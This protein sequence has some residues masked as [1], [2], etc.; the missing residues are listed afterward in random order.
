[1]TPFQL[2][3]DD[4][5]HLILENDLSFSEYIRQ[6]QAMIKK[7]RNTQLAMFASRNIDAESIINANSPYEFYPTQPIFSENGRLKYGV[8]LIHGLLDS[9]FSLRE[10]GRYLQ[11]KGMLA[12]AIAL[13]GHGTVPNDLLSVSYTDWI[14]AVRYGVES[15]RK[16]V[17]HVFLIGYSTGAALSI[18]QALEDSHIKGIILLSPAIR[19]KAPVDLMVS[20]H[21]F[22]KWAK[23]SQQREWLYLEN[24][25]D[26]TK[27]LSIP[28]NAIHQVSRLTDIIHTKRQQHPLSTPVF[29]IISREDETISSDRAIEFFMSLKNQQNRMLL[30]TSHEH[31][32]SD[33]RIVTR[34]SQ[35]PNLNIKHLSHVSLPFSPSNK[36]YG[37]EGDYFTLPSHDTTSIY[38]AYNRV[39][40][41]IY[42]F[43][44]Q[45]KLLRKKRVELKYNPD[46]YFMADQINAF[47]LQEK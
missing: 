26:Y 3:T 33:S 18:Y 37:K 6:Y 47:I 1:M 31:A 24:E 29:V 43:L 7:R 40:V 39:E 8:L 2:E 27:Y 44:H 46:F 13:P 16:E 15:L 9:P 12:R 30:Y 22:M 28:F 11:A 41:K 36:H 42:R 17:E 32:Y 10:I 23:R 19:I 34:Y 4:H 5:P 35:Y 38:G 14:N 25:I 20:W 21:Q 45:Y